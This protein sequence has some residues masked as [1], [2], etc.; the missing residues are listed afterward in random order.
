MQLP[1]IDADALLLCGR[2][3]ML[4]SAQEVIAEFFL[5]RLSARNIIFLVIKHFHTM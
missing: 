1:D 2:L 3:N 4:A 5:A